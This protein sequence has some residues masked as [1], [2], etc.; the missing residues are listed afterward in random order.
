MSRTCLIHTYLYVYCLIGDTKYANY[1]IFVSVNEVE[2]R[3]LFAFGLY[4]LKF[5]MA[6]KM[7]FRM[8]RTCLLHTYLYV[9]CLI[10]G[11]R[12]VNYRIFVSVNEVES[13]NIFAFGLYI[14]KFKM[15]AKTLFRICRTC[16]IHTY[17]YVYGLNGGTKYAI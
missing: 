4:S 3:N 2:S 12:Y 10:G 16:S 17:L 13:R 6:A 1:R 5:K 14:L 9:Y 7:Q 11:T 8:S 15:A